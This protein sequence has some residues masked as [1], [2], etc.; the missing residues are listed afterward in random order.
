MACAVQMGAAVRNQLTTH[1][2][3]LIV[4]V[5]AMAGCNAGVLAMTSPDPT[6]E[7][8]LDTSET[9]AAAFFS[10][11]V[12]PLLVTRCLGCHAAGRTGPAFIVADPDV[13]TSLLSWPALVD[14]DTPGDSRMLTKGEHAGPAWA[15][16]ESAVVERWLTLEAALSAMTMPPEP[17]LV[18]APVEPIVGFNDIDLGSFG[19][20][21]SRITFI[22]ARAAS[23]LLIADLAVVAGEDGVLVDHPVFVSF[24][25]GATVA[26][27][28]DTFEGVELSVDP[29]TAADLGG[30]SLVL[31]DFPE[32][33]TLAVHFDAIGPQPAAS[34]T[35]SPTP[36]PT[37]GCAQVPLFT[38]H[39]RPVL[40]A[41]CTGCHGG[42]DSG[43]TAA[44]DMQALADTSDA[45]QR[46]ACNEILTR[47]N[48]ADVASSML[49][50]ASD[51]ESSVSHDFKFASTGA[52]DDFQLALFR[53]L[54]SE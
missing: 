39:A 10:A 17:A 44:V 21:G 31:V 15:A 6:D 9:D 7:T 48:R 32:G 14:L 1:G 50:L 36:T 37:S 3:L 51:P 53:W 47:V 38:E 49:L 42:S 43:A 13:R 29:G 16:R 12:E 30:G 28:F 2:L 54:A 33:S 23:G 22:A 45:S 8:P 25:D 34:P 27:A 52:R 26:D 4:L 40:T 11:Q 41:R 5:L 19:L 46:S 18:T 24:V 20:P 35:P